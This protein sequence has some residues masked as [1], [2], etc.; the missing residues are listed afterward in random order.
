MIFYIVLIV[1]G[2]IFLIL[3]SLLIINSIKLKSLNLKIIEAEKNIT[4]VLKEKYELLVNINNIM[5]TKDKED[6]LKDIELI[7]VDKI[8]NFELNNH[9][10]KYDKTIT[11]LIEYNKEIIFDEEEQEEFEKLRKTDLNRLAIEKYYNDNATIMNKLI[12][13]FPASI[14]AKFKK[15]KE[16]EIFSNKKEEIF[17]ILKK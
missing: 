12:N 14:I 15:Y 3:F 16:K 8:S 11:E 4:D 2:I 13:I 5:K 1:I 9:L 6:F 7:E 10:T 17:E